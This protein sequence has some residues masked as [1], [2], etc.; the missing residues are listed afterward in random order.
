MRV[1]LAV[2]CVTAALAP[3]ANAAT[4]VTAPTKVVKVGKQKVGYRTFGTGRPLVMIMGLGGTMGSWD[5]TFLDALAA[6]GHRIVLLDNEGVGK[7]TRLRGKLTIRRMGDTAAGLIARLKLKRPDVAGWSMGGMIAQSLA[8]RHAKSLRRLVLMA[9][10]PGDGKA[11]APG[12]GVLT[13]LTTSTDVNALLGFLFPADQTAALNA[14]VADIVKRH[15]FNPVAPRSQFAKQVSASGAWL[16]GQ[17]PDGRR[18]AN[19]KL[20]TLVGGGELDQL[21]PVANQRHIAD[22]IKG[23]Q[24]VTYPDASHGFFIQHQD[25]FVPRLLTFLK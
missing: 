18:V 15:P 2:L 4:A 16:V 20:P 25:D 10:A 24:L 6:G 12:S 7:T 3:A 22:L 9:T 17:D 14:Y 13:T 5:P 19:L 23:S 1:L 11:T 21:L 8:V